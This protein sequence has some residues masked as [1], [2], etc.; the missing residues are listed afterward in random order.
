MIL[1]YFYD[2]KK[3]A[4]ISPKMAIFFKFTL[5]FKNISNFFPLF[6]W[7]QKKEYPGSWEK[8]KKKF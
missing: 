6:F 1:M 4:K 7:V 2:V 3:L 8:R 5:G